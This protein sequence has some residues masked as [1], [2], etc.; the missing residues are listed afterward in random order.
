MTEVPPGMEDFESLGFR[1]TAGSGTGRT[2]PDEPRKKA[3]YQPQVRKGVAR[4]SQLLRN[5]SLVVHHSQKKS[6]RARENVAAGL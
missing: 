3:E 2:T 5:S 1:A 4:C 6:R